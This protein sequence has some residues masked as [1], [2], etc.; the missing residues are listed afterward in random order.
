MDILAK[1]NM[2]RLLVFFI[3]IS[4]LTQGLVFADDRSVSFFKED[5]NPEDDCK[6]CIKEGSIL[7]IGLKKKVEDIEK[8]TTKSFADNTGRT[9]SEIILFIDPESPLSDGAVNALA[10]FK[11]DHPSWKCR[12][13]MIAG[14]RSLKGMLLQKKSYFSNDIEFSVDINGEEEGEFNITTT[15][16]YVIIYHGR[17]YKIAGQPDL[18]EIVSKLDK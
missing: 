12:G 11:Q 13:I 1:E 6:G 3:G 8:E 17:S 7:N 5:A 18:D 9:G 10:K 4:L 14:L 15:P 16:S 2:L